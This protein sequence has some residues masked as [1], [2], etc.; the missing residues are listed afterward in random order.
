MRNRAVDQF[1]QVAPARHVE[2]LREFS[3]QGRKVRSLLQRHQLRQSCFHSL[4]VVAHQLC[5]AH[6]LGHLGRHAH[7]FTAHHLVPQRQI[8]LHQVIQ[9]GGAGDHRGHQ[10]LALLGLGVGVHQPLQGPHPQPLL[11]G[12]QVEQLRLDVAGQPAVLRIV[13]DAVGAPVHKGGLDTHQGHQGGECEGESCAVH[14][15]WVS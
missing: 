8:A 15:H 2:H 11:V 10:T 7:A 13:V 4:D 5:Y 14:Q 3:P 1:A 9:V 12:R 6:E